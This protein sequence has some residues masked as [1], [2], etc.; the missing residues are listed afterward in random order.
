MMNFQS[1][2]KIE[3][4]DKYIDIAIKRANKNAQ[5]IAKKAAKKTKDKLNKVKTIELER[6]K[7]I[8]SSLINQLERILKNFPNLDELPDFYKELVKTTLEYGKLKRSLGAI[9]WA[10]KSVKDLSNKYLIKIKRTMHIDSIIG[11]RKE[12]LG[13]VCSIIKQVKRDFF[14][15]EDARRIMKNYPCV[16][17]D[18]FT[19]AIAG[20]PNV[21]KSTL[22]AKLSKAK[23]KIASYAFT[24]KG[25]N[26]GYGV[27][28]IY[29]KVQFIDTPGT[30]NRFEKMNAIEQQAYLAIKHLADMIIYVF[31]LTEP[32]PLEQQMKLYNKL[33]KLKTTIAYLSK[34]DVLDKKVMSDFLKKV[35]CAK[36][37]KILKKEIT[38]K[39]V[40]KE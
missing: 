27:F 38:K 16:K 29:K 23:P 8:K 1:I 35:E 39:W 7:I 10:R 5:A 37:I 30:L 4:A 12:Y 15:L 31:D 21:G 9:N 2:P 20:F 13:R 40:A 14:N 34:T 19:V 25:L 18:M 36:N 6:L 11:Y 3:A 22:L 32:Y 33:R 17:T 24:T 26:I 28:E